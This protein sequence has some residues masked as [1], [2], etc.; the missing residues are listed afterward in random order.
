MDKPRPTISL[1]VKEFHEISWLI[2]ATIKCFRWRLEIQEYTTDGQACIDPKSMPSDPF[3]C[4]LTL[5]T[6]LTVDLET[7]R[8]YLKKNILFLKIHRDHFIQPCGAVSPQAKSTAGNTYLF[9]SPALATLIPVAGESLPRIILLILPG[10][11]FESFCC[12]SFKSFRHIAAFFIEVELIYSIVLVSGVHQSDSVKCIYA[13]IHILFS[14]SF[15]IIVYY[16][17]LNIVHSA[18]YSKS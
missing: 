16:K 1:E 15:S 14:Y 2:C 10:G 6:W 18:T 4:A 17:I 13:Y 12:F 3:C 7:E 11:V 8:S 9:S 5:R